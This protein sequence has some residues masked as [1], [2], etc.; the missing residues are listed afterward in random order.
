[1][2]L[3]NSEQGVQSGS[4][5]EVVLCQSGTGER[6]IQSDLFRTVIRG[7]PSDRSGQ[8]FRRADEELQ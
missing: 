3:V 7:W 4:L 1:M 2:K 6:S 5:E 8:R